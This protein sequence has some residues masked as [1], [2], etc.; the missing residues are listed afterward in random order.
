[1]S[2][3]TRVEA[4]ASDTRPVE[5]RSLANIAEA[6]R[7]CQQVDDTY[8]Q[9]TVGIPHF[10]ESRTQSVAR[11]LSLSRVASSSLIAGIATS[12]MADG[13]GLLAAGAVVAVAALVRATAAVQSLR[14]VS[15]KG[16]QRVLDVGKDAAPEMRELVASHAHSRAWELANCYDVSWDMRGRLQRHGARVVLGGDAIY[17]KS[18]AE[19]LNLPEVSARQIEHLACDIQQLHHSEREAVAKY[20]YDAL[21]GRARDGDAKKALKSFVWSC[22]PENKPD[23]WDPS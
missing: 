15:D 7:L 18:I 10:A 21:R 6:R 5:S 2:A 1:M 20:A 3:A 14:W 23:P 16:A 17:V 11:W 12:V 19:V 4:A 13:Y 22:L 9:I 8:H